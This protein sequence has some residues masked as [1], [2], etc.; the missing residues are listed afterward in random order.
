MTDQKPAQPQP[1]PPV[2]ARRD[3]ASGILYVGIDLGTSHTAISASNGTRAV[4]DSIVG[5]PKDVVS[6]KLLKKEVLYGQEA[7]ANRLA[8][9]MYRPLERG[10]IKFSDDPAGATPEDVDGNLEAAKALVRR[11]VELAGPK[12]G[13]LVYGVVGC[14][15]Q[16]SIR[17]KQTIIEIARES[18]DSVVI[19][20]EPF[21]V[22]YGLEKLTDCLVID[23]G[24]GT[25][26]LCRMKGAMPD[27]DDQIT[28]PIAGDFL[29]GEL[30]KLFKERC[31]NAAFTI[32]MVKSIKEKHSFVTESA[33]PVVV[34]FPVAGKPVN[35]DVTA[36]IRKGLRKIIPPICEAIDKL[37]ATFDPEFQ[38]RIRNNVLLAGGGSQIH[39]LDRALEE[40][41]DDFGGGKVTLVE[42]PVYAGANG[43]LKIAYDMPL[44]TWEQL[45]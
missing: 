26:D 30:M 13:E 2:V 17:N 22:A 16:A 9:R 8:L 34:T 41:L 29:D 27:E 14:P 5:Y 45:R 18:L 20:S 3:G 12:P 23:I 33:E 19:C 25:T 36:E 1:K 28:L 7:L 42:E 32:N 37:V 11:A 44:E 38:A 21:S 6:R 15:A 4:F 43:A 35:F 24:A 39:G 31:P 10:A 40:A